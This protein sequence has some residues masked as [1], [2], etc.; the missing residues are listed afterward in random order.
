MGHFD[1]LLWLYFFPILQ[2][3][4]QHKPHTSWKLIPQVVQKIWRFS[5]S[6]LTIFIKFLDF[7]ACPCY[8]LTNDV[9]I[10]QKMSKFFHFQPT[11]KRL[12]NNCI[13][14]YWF[15]TI[16]A[17]Y[18]F[19]EIWRGVQIDP[20]PEKT[21]LKKLCLIRVNIRNPFRKLKF[22]RNSQIVQRNLYSSTSTGFFTI[23]ISWNT[24]I[25]W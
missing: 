14:L 20:N 25:L 13:T 11:L 22:V 10:W 23:A 2:L 6:A 8:K 24:W 19:L 12:F 15:N 1:L 4:Y 5:S 21:T 7:L 16:V 17:L 9:D 3:L 18:W